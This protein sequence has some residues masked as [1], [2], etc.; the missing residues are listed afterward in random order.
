MGYLEDL[1]GVRTIIDSSGAELPAASTLVADSTIGIAYS[2]TTKRYTIGA[3][4]TARLSN[5]Y[6]VDQG[7]LAA[8]GY[9]GSPSRPYSTIATGVAAAAAVDLPQGSLVLIAPGA[10]DENGITLPLVTADIIIAAMGPLPAPEASNVA[11]GSMTGNAATTATIAF[12]GI[13]IGDIVTQAAG[14]AI[15]DNCTVAAVTAKSVVAVRSW[16]LNVTT[17]ASGTLGCYSC[18][19]ITSTIVVGGT[20]AAFIRCGFSGAATITFSG[21]AGIVTMDQQSRENFVAA[22]GYVVNGTISAP[23]SLRPRTGNHMS[24]RDDFLLPSA[25]FLTVAV[26]YSQLA[27]VSANSGAGTGFALVTNPSRTEVGVI[28]CSTGTTGTGYTSA[29][30]WGGGATTGCMFT[31]AT[32]DAF[33]FEWKVATPTAVSNGTD[34]YKVRIGLG[35]IATGVDPTEGIWFEWDAN[36]ATQIK[37]KTATASVTTAVQTSSVVAGT[38]YHKLRC[39]KVAGSTDVQFFIDGERQSSTGVCPVAAVVTPYA[40][41]TKSAGTNARLLALDWFDFDHEWDAGR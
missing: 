7:T 33:D 8:S 17:A 23:A 11:L 21:S 36:T 26:A 9:D 18:D 6:Y 15:F 39:M 24:I 34:T 20:T 4:A 22:G 38:T 35:N 12:I 1:A 32:A 16:L 27:W 41:I 29:V 30:A 31:L 40:N 2:A 10:G 5:V 28:S 19:L 25:S 14:K 3:G 13:Y 37:T